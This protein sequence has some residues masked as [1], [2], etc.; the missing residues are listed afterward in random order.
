VKRTSNIC[1]TALPTIILLFI[2]LVAP[3]IEVGWHDKMSSV[4]LGDGM[5]LNRQGPPIFT[6]LV[7]MSPTGTRLNNGWQ[8]EFVTFAQHKYDMVK[9]LNVNTSAAVDTEYGNYTLGISFFDGRTFDAN[10]LTFVFTKTRNF[11]TML[12]SPLR[13]GSTFTNLVPIYQNT[14]HLQGEALHARITSKFG[15][16]YVR[17]EESA[18]FVSVIYG[19][20]YTSASIKQ[21]FSLSTSYSYDSATFSSF[22][23]SYFGSTNTSLSIGYSLYSSSANPLPSYLNSSGLIQNYQD[24]LTFVGKLETYVNSM[25]PADAKTTGYIL[26][27]IQTA[28]GY[29]DIIGGYVP[30]PID[31]DDSSDF[32]QAITALQVWQRRLQGRGPMNWLNPQGQQVIASK[33]LDIEN[34]LNAMYSI[35]SNNYTTGAPLYL[36]SDVVT[37]LANLSDIKLPEIYIMDSFIYD[38]SVTYPKLYILGRVD[39]GDRNLVKPFSTLSEIETNNPNSAITVDLDYDAWHFQTNQLDLYPSGTRYGRLQ[40]LFTNA[41]WACLTNSATNPDLN[42]FFVVSQHL[43]HGSQPAANWSLAIS[44]GDT[45]VDE[46][47]FLD[48]RSGGCGASSQVSS[49][50]SVSIAGTSPPA[51]GTVG[52]IQPVTVQI[53]NQSSIQAYGTTVSFVLN[54]G[55]EYKDANGSQGYGSLSNRVVTYT[56]GPL[57][58][59]ASADIH[60]QVIPLQTNAVVPGTTPVLAFASGLTNS[61]TGTAGFWPIQSVPPILGVT[62]SPG[63]I[64]FDWW[65]DTDRLLFERSSVLGLGASWSP[66]TN[67]LVI[68]GSHRFLPS[69]VAGQ[70]GYFRLRSQ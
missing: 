32:L 38:T 1:G 25:T 46:M 16:H 12:Y 61:A 15:T 41:Q 33:A 31:P 13:F 22:V 62:P 40:N 59:N 18:A 49:N 37:Y 28:P 68:N 7:E 51:I 54:N 17:G 67:G 70:Q 14:N 23:S 66:A 19:F 53:T 63:G 36:P 65:S 30:L 69:T 34:Y 4:G 29:F 64:L 39:C 9:T 50:V 58:G 35:A 8:D 55:F 47:A 45:I 56:V 43:T 60:L 26:D 2:P 20:H 24:F 21:R 44:D 52:R 42:G 10:D 6:G 5:R 48:T 3:A 27:P 11:G 57:P